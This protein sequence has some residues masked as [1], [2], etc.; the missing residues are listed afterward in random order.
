MDDVRKKTISS[1][2]RFGLFMDC[3][4]MVGGP[5]EKGLTQIKSIAEGAT[6]Q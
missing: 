6:R 5:F 2:R 4:K 3:E 1:P